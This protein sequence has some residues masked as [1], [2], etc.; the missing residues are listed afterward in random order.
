MRCFRKQIYVTNR[1]GVREGINEGKFKTFMFLIL[2]L[3]EG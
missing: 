2:N 3:Y 1:K